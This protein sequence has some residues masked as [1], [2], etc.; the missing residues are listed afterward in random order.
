MGCTGTLVWAVA[1]LLSAFLVFMAA[2]RGRDYRRPTSPA[3]LIPIASPAPPPAFVAV[4]ETISAPVVVAVAEAVSAH[5]TPVVPPAPPELDI[6][7]GRRCRT[8]QRRTGARRRLRASE[9]PECKSGDGA[10][11]QNKFSHEV[12]L[13]KKQILATRQR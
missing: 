5:P 2:G 11:S 10:R 6:L 13:S 1:V 4:A 8:F 12:T 9:K 7:R 3:F